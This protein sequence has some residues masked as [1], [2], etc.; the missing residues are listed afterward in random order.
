MARDVRSV[1]TREAR[2]LKLDP[3]AVLAVAAGEGGFVNRRND[4]GDLGGGGSFGPFQLYTQ[5]ALPQKY[6][7]NQRAADAWAWSPAGIRYALGRMASVG[8]AGLTGAQA[9][10]TII[11][12]FERPADPSTSVRNAVGRLGKTGPMAQRVPQ[13]AA[14]AY[15]RGPANVVNSPNPT[16]RAA[17]A[18]QFVSSMLA[19]SQ[20]SLRGDFASNW[21]AIQGLTD[22]RRQLAEAN[23][24]A[25]AAEYQSRQYGGTTVPA[26][27]AVP[28]GVSG[29]QFEGVSGTLQ[30]ILEAADAQI[31]KPYVWGAESPAE[32]GF[33]CSGLIDWAYRQAG[34]KLPGRLTTQT[35]MKQG[36]SV[37]GK[38][39]RPGDWLITNGGQHMVMYVGNGQVI[40]APRTGERVQ[41]QP[42]SR[43]DGDIVDVRRV[44]K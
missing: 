20:N 40:A 36:I 27:S 22:A 15:Q 9:V 41:Y 44:L 33:D 16:A 10:E 43:F 26:G 34:V 23:S 38:P 12:K 14:Q 25:V 4:I 37:K 39:Y 3:A 6:R 18:Q 19:M 32:G 13:A 29:R 11:R 24:E 5:G 8:A 42:V 31:G 7:G 17:A 1:I 35:A 28:S 21:Q 2:R 30:G